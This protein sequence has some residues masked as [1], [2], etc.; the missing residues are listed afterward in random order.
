MK[1]KI[2]RAAAAAIIC[3]SVV[4]C[5]GCNNFGSIDSLLEA[6]KL[7][8]RQQ[9][10]RLALEKALG[11]TDIYYRYP[12]TGRSRAAITMHDVYGDEREEAIVLYSIGKKAA[13]SRV[14]I[15]TADDYGGWSSLCDIAPES[16][17]SI[18][19]IDFAQFNQ[20]GYDQLLI[21][22]RLFSGN[23]LSVYNIRTGINTELFSI[24]YSEITT[25]DLNRDGD[26]EIIVFSSNSAASNES[27]TNVK[28]YDYND[29]DGLYL[30]TETTMKAV[31]SFLQ[32]SFAQ[33]W[34]NVP[35]VFIDAQISS[36]VYI[37]EV[38]CFTNNQLQSIF[39]G[40]P[41]TRSV[42]IV[43]RDVDGDG[44]LEVPLTNL[45]PGY[46]TAAAS[47]RLSA[48]AWYGY[49]SN[50]TGTTN[51]TAIV[52][53]T[54]NYMMTLKPEWVKDVTVETTSSPDEWTF[55]HYDFEMLAF[56]DR[57]MTI[58]CW[59]DTEWEANKSNY[60]R[61]TQFFS[62]GNTVFTAEIYNY[63]EISIEELQSLFVAL[64]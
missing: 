60:P 61:Q 46:E 18:D 54:W 44:F 30:M 51:C 4:I 25:A 52:N 13:D 24:P 9:E 19:R 31:S 15:L 62:R 8:S 11:T 23:I 14:H 35:A 42:K 26:S 56:G 39:S 37:T 59:I 6:P 5:S 38:L 40:E 57:I 34:D 17:N 63:N 32:I 12:V 27:L 10:I 22:W 48:I 55:C 3:L 41:A 28:A 7:T 1:N 33:L 45:L 16:G 49:L 21:G 64:Q 36:N 47:E 2:I 53:S 58:R 29:T 50:F 20:T 43:S